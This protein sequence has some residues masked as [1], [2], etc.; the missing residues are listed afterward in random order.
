MHEYEA[1]KETKQIGFD[2]SRFKVEKTNITN[3]RQELVEKF[4]TKLNNSRIAGGY[5]PLGAAFYAS[6]MAMIPTDELYAFYKELDNSKNFSALWWHKCQVKV[7]M[8]IFCTGCNKEVEPRL[9]DGKEIYPHREDLYNLPFWKCD[10]CNNYVGCHHKTSNPTKPLG[11][12]PTKELKNA[13]QHIHALLDPLWKSGKIGRRKLYNKITKQLGWNFH[14]A[15]L[16]T[17]EEARNAY[18]VIREIKKTVD[19]S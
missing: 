1:P 16:K 5:K 12:I 13:R 8:K 17:I 15:E 3:E 7:V 9:T 19:N 10:T 18:R 14:T 11:V 4:V 2:L 6:R